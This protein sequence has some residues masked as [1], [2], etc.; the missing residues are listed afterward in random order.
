MEVTVA[1]RVVTFKCPQ[2][3][4][5]TQQYAHLTVYHNECQNAPRGVVAVKMEPQGAE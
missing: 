1:K 4:H 3:N 5:T 2:C